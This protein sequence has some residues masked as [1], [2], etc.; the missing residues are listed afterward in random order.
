M[1]ERPLGRLTPKSWFENIT[2]KHK[3]TRQ[4][5]TEIEHISEKLSDSYKFR[6]WTKFKIL[7]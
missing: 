4:D 7:L 5:K 1:R 6:L 3:T 2:D